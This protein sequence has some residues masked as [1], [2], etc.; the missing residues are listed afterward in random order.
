MEAMRLQ[1]ADLP[2]LTHWACVSRNLIPSHALMLGW[3]NLI[4]R[5]FN[6]QGTTS[7]KCSPYSEQV[8]ITVEAM[9]LL[10][11]QLS[12]QQEGKLSP[13]VG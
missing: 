7:M 5:I 8:R 9:R 3:P 4:H 2:S 13:H 11:A 12:V 10:K 1:K 6:V